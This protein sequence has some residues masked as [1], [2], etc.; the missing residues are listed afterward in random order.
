MLNLIVTIVSV[1]ALIGLTGLM[2]F[3]LLLL[4]GLPYGNMAW[5]GKYD[6]LPLKLRIGSLIS[7]AVI[8][9]GIIVLLEK[10]AIVFLVNNQTILNISSWFFVILF[11]LS[12]L[13]NINSKSEKE[14][15]IMT[16]LAIILTLSF[17]IVSLFA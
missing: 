9:Y 2:I 16:P 17:L 15:K 5:G 10:S 7:A 8:L 11:G 13:G 14:K 3:Q 4:F 1:I 6:V 12:T